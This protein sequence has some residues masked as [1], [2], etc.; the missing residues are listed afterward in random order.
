MQ[1]LV[2]LFRFPPLY[3]YISSFC[4]TLIVWIRRLMGETCCLSAFGLHVVVSALL[5]SLL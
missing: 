4:D 5:N 3:M 1:N 2:F